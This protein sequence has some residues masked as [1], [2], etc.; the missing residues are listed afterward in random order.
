MTK[1]I[2]CFLAI[3]L[4]CML[5]S[6]AVTSDPRQGGFISGLYG[7]S[8]GSYENRIQQ[9]QADL[10][11]KKDINKKL[12][13]ESQVLN[14]EALSQEQ[15][16]GLEK[17]KLAKMEE[18][19]AKLESDIKQYGTISKKKKVEL[20]ALRENLQGL[21][22]QVKAQESAYADLNLTGNCVQDNAPC[23]VLEAEIARLAEE[24]KQLAK[25]YQALSKA[26][27]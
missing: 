1:L 24:Y 21:R 3:F 18:N 4:T 19:I 12:Q 14:K 9:Q 15:R 25:H 2:R 23:L 22:K 27:N 11:H 8:S 20:A 10:D 6:C 7:I 5:T 17:Q 26:S 13:E 16:M